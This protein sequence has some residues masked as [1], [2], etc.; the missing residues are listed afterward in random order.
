MAA[1]LSE[2]PYASFIHRVEKPARYLGG[3]FHQT[4]KDPKTVRLSLALAFPD[5]YDIGMSH[6]GTK[7]LYSL[8]NKEPDL[9]CERAFAP[10]PDMERELRDRGLPVLSCEN[11]RPLRDFDVLG[12]SLQYELTFTNLLNLLDLSGIALRSDQRREEDPIILA[13]GPIATQPEPMAPFVDAFLIGDAEAILPTLL[14]TIAEGREAGVS[15]QE[16]LVSLARLGGLYCPALYETA[17]DPRSGFEVVTGPKIDEVCARPKRQIVENLSDYPFPDDS[18]VAAAQ[19]IFDRMSV[20]IARGCTEGCRFCQAGMIY[21]P[22]RERDPQDV[23][24]TVLRAVD[25]GGYDEAGLTTL[26]TADYSCISPLMSELMKELRARKVSLSVASLRAYGLDEPTLDEMASYRAQGLTFAPEAGTQRMRDVINKNVT[27]EDITRTAHRI[28][29]RGW[30]RMK[31]YF[32]I[33]LPTEEDEDVR[34]IMDLGHRMKEIG[35]KYQGRRAEITVSV[36]SHVPKPHT[37]FQWVAMDSLEEIERKQDLLQEQ[38][39]RHRLE[40]RRHDPR[41]SMLEGILGR[42]DRRV[43]TVIEKAFLKGCRF[44]GWDE[45]LDWQAWVEAIEESGIDPS[46]YLGTIALD[47]RTPWDHL[48]M[49]LEERFLQTDYKRAMASKLSPPCGKPAGAQV[50]PADLQSH[51][52]D[53]RRLVCYHCGVACDLEGM[54]EERRDFLEKLRAFEPRSGDRA[55]ATREAKQERIARGAAPHQLDQGEALRLRFTMR[56]FGADSMTGHLDLVRKLPR[57]FRRAGVEVFYTEGYHPKPSIAFGPALPLG[58]QGLAEPF[59]IKLV[60]RVDATGQDQRPD[61]AE[62]LRRLNAVAESGIE[63]MSCEILEEGSGRLGRLLSEAEY[64]VRP[65][66]QPRPDLDRIRAALDRF[67]RA[68]SWPLLLSRK[69]KEHPIDLRQTA[70]QVDLVDPSASKEIDLSWLPSPQAPTFRLRLRLGGS[71]Q[72]RPEEVLRAVLKEDPFDLPPVRIL[73]LGFRIAPPPPP[74]PEEASKVGEKHLQEQ[75]QF[76]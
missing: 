26:S 3:E 54:R 6:L 38:A 7:I 28:Y 1:S 45:H 73:R 76:G 37:P 71:A 51:D 48:D 19:A 65:D 9:L 14:R 16:I 10:W 20:E 70:P 49:Q 52:A 34:G 5:L 64:L 57:I 42:G 21:R 25:K 47:A 22:V 17:V 53:T 72:V 63:F 39:R 32:M 44:D 68:E 67:R 11:R 23:I 18:P 15:R 24:D 43:A 8:V 12:F 75:G 36:S 2:H 59:E 56:K 55:R 46:L 69:R 41:T 62:L 74:P 50:H 27:E 13:G 31:L 58:V 61:P 66:F 40:F 30:K 4:V 29:E 60:R 35:A 33:G